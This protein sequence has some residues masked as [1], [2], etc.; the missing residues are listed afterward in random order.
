[1]EKTNEKITTVC[2]PTCNRPEFLHRALIGLVENLKKYGRAPRILVIDDSEEPQNA[3]KTREICSSHGANYQGKIECMDRNDRAEMAKILAKEKGVSLEVLNFALCGDKLSTTTAGAVRNTFL[4]KTRGEKIL[5]VDDDVV[6]NF[7]S[8]IFE[9]P[10]LFSIENPLEYW[11]LEGDETP[12]TSLFKPVEVDLLDIHESMLGKKAGEILGQNIPDDMKGM[13]IMD[14]YMGAYGDSPMESHI[15]LLLLPQVYEKFKNISPI[16]YKAI[17][18]TRK[19]IQVPFSTT[20]YQGPIC[21]SMVVGIDNRQ[22]PPP[23]I[24]IGRAQD[25][26][27]GTTRWTAFPSKLSVYLPILIGHERPDKKIQSA[28][29]NS[30]HE[31]TKINRIIANFIEE[32]IN[33]VNINSSENLQ[34]IGNKFINIAQKSESEFSLF[35]ETQCQKIT[36]IVTDHVNNILKNSPEMPDFWISDMNSMISELEF[37]DPKFFMDNI[38]KSP[39]KNRLTI[40]QKWM[41]LYG[42]LLQVWYKLL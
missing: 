25:L 16:Q 37:S 1:M 30:V 5:I 7:F 40:L 14:T 13:E 39:N 2:I 41:G 21:T 19:I 18:G 32:E 35:M 33:N 17:K 15:P 6:Y 10:P 22:L 3:Q 12:P 4:L 36:K 24:P 23:F 34:I 27:F 29:Y 38:T 20:V 31:V 26:V 8:P 28:V 42:Q 9:E 11:F